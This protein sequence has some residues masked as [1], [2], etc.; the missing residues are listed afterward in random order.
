ML[1][2]KKN[3]AASL[4]VDVQER[5]RLK[6]LARYDIFGTPAEP[7]FDRM[8][9]LAS[10]LFAVPVALVTLIGEHQQWLKSCYGVEL[11]KVQNMDRELTF[12]HHAIKRASTMV[13]LDALQDPRFVD[14]PYVTMEQGIRFYAGAPLLTPDGHALGTLCLI[15]Q[16]PHAAFSDR[17]QALLE[18]LAALTMDEVL[19]RHSIEE[20]SHAQYDLQNRNERITDILE[21][22]DDAFFS[23]DRQWYFSYLNSQAE[24]LLK[25]SKYDLLG[26]NIWQAFPEA[27]GSL[28]ERKYREAMEQQHSLRFEAFY[29]PLQ[30]WFEVRVYPSKEG[31]SVYFADINARKKAEEERDRLLAETEYQRMEAES[32]VLSL[33]KIRHELEQ[34]NQLK[35][36]FLASMSHELRS[37]LTAIMGFSDMLRQGLYGEVNEEQQRSLEDISQAGQHLLDV[38]NDILNIAKIEAGRMEL[39]LE[40]IDISEIADN[41]RS[42]FRAKAKQQDIHI[43]VTAPSLEI[44]ADAR[45]L[46]QILYNLVSN[47]LKFTAR[48]G[49]V[50]IVA[51]K[52]ARGV[53]VNVIDTGVGIAEADQKKLFQ[54]FVQLENAQSSAHQG[55]GLGLALVKNF[56]E[57]HQGEVYLKSKPGEGSCFGFFLPTQPES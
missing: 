44:R 15:D 51:S 50:S 33:Q 19:L 45:K 40:T 3:N 12:C 22:I 34:A 14:N 9:K 24:S 54:N 11:A 46:R 18:N 48:G 5:T 37:P 7:S 56:V 1:D 31:L 17:D 20:L 28:F 57:L 4:T 49:T 27:V 6:A 47:A 38:I 36:E 29:P 43:N 2:H 23:L 55:T 13:V 35:R 42:V 52:E 39:Q 41:I 16:E 8:T 32:R 21:S 30:T 25:K 26:S 53:Q 10:S